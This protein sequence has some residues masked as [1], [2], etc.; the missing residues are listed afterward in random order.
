MSWAI[1]AH[2][3]NR[4]CSRV[5]AVWFHCVLRICRWWGE[6][7]AS[8]SWLPL[9]PTG[10]IISAVW[11]Y[12]C[13]LLICEL[14]A[15]LPL[16]PSPGA[17]GTD[18]LW[19]IRIQM[20][21]ERWEAN[22]AGNWTW[23]VWHTRRW[24]PGWKSQIEMLCLKSSSPFYRCLSFTSGGALYW[25]YSAAHWLWKKDIWYFA[26]SDK[27]VAEVFLMHMYV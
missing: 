17:P 14:I 11:G 27:W 9:K 5:M 18:C 21:H 19:A 13:T 22:A 10:W 20:L 16:K 3:W 15:P 25:I 6:S 26:S 2:K 12:E 1:C 4:V 8:I 23:Q 7:S 24:R